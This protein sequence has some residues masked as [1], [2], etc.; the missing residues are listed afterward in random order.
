MARSK[1]ESEGEKQKRDMQ[2]LKSKTDAELQELLERQ[3]RILRQKY[4]NLLLIFSLK[5]QVDQNFVIRG[6]V[7]KLADKGAR[8]ENL[9]TRIEQEL[10][11]REEMGKLGGALTQV[12]LTDNME[13]NVAAGE[14]RLK[15]QETSSDP[16]LNFLQ[17]KK[18]Y[19]IKFF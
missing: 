4:E 5:I 10:A 8:V 12:Q 13:W 9:K 11:A 2:D 1:T 14:D 15:S 7:A 19:R 17:L 6:L 16:L 18:E 3:T